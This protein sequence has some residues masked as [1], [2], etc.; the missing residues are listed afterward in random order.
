M[1]LLLFSCFLQSLICFC[2]TR[3]SLN[4][5]SNYVDIRLTDENPVKYI[6][7]PGFPTKHYPKNYEIQY[8][9]T[10]C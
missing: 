9:V 10:V 2:S 7:S 5:R 8:D 3:S 1:Q 4:G 6:K